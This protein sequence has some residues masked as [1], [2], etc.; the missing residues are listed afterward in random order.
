ML[1]GGMKRRLMIARALIHRPRILLLDEPTAGV[2]ISLRRQMWEFITRANNSGLTII[3]TT[4]NL[5]EAETLCKRVGIINHGEIIALGKTHEL[6]EQLHSEA[7]LLYTDKDI[8]KLPKISVP[9]KKEN[10]RTIEVEMPKD[11]SVTAI[12][13]ELKKHN[14][15]IDR[16]K[17]K[18][19]RLEELF[20]RLVEK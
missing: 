17:N 8:G 3:L 10:R 19:N 18:T 7:V 9:L 2:D 6:L 5:E 13:A 15:T 14:I 1:S 12:I 4:H 11:I 16:M 20:L